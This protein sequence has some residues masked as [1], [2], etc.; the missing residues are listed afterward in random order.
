[1]NQSLLHAECITSFSGAAWIRH[2]V[3]V[4]AALT[5]GFIPALGQ[6]APAKNSFVDA[7]HRISEPKQSSAL[8][9]SSQPADTAQPAASEANLNVS[10]DTLLN[11]WNSP[12]LTGDW[13]GVRSKLAEKW[14]I[15]VGG[16]WD[17]DYFADP[18]AGNTR[19]NVGEGNW[20]RIRGILSIDMNKVVHI[21][22][23]SLHITSTYN[24]GSD[25]GANMG[26]L[27][28]AV[29]NDTGYHQL[30]LDSWWARQD[31]FNSK[32]S[33]YVGQISGVDF[34]GYLPGDFAHFETLE[35]YYAP[36]A[37]YNSFE[38]FDPLTTPAAMIEINPIK[39]L[40]FRSMIQSITEG[41]PADPAISGFYNW[42]NNPSGTSEAIRDGGVWNNEIAYLYGSG[43]AHFGASYSGARAYTEWTGGASSGT[44]VTTP[45]FHSNS[46]GGD[47]NF[48]WILKQYVYRPDGRSDRGIDLGATY[49]Y[50]PADKGFLPYNRQLVVTAEANGLLAKRPKD[51]INFSFNYLDIRGP[52]QT[53]I[54][55]SEKVYELNYALHINRWLMW[56]PNLQI[57]ED[58]GANP[59]NGTGVIVGFRSMITF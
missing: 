45:G 24:V 47:E 19:A 8:S 32:L 12:T 6:D 16:F 58:I 53:S 4:L 52:L 49:V 10:S 30:R 29:G 46:N 23:L 38:S 14:G 5:T 21:K 55:K 28:N 41:N 48:Y 9:N 35:P 27:V 15:T 37:L 43:E 2:L 3:L 25:V 17:N 7:S 34:F 51:S 20:S 26:S 33:L 31:L 57:H 42:T 22:G 1:M 40:R 36:F 18:S 11:F 44:L 13:G 50:G 39:H 54:F 59:L 56:M